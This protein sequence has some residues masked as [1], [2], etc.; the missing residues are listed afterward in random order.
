MKLQ[1]LIARFRREVDDLK[2]PLSWTDEEVVDYLNDAEEE[3]AMRARLLYDDYT[4]ALT[5][6]AVTV[7]T[8][9]YRRDTRLFEIRRAWLHNAADTQ[10][11]ELK[12]RSRASLDAAC[13]DWRRERG[14]PEFLVIDD[15]S[16]LLSGVHAETYTLRLEGYRLPIRPMALE[17]RTSDEPEIGQQH[18][19]F[20]IEWAKYRAYMKPDSETLNPGGAKLALDAFE[21]YF[22]VRNLANQ[23]LDNQSDRPHRNRCY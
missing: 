15:A 5:D 14:A 22:G 7:G 16:L 13:P 10:R 2:D 9:R 3:A 1:D 20:L 17:K 4:T 12:I 19:R 6:T 11:T 21:G 18:H 8:N 23:G